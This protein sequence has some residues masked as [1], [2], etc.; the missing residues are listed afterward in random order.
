MVWPG[1]LVKIRA[2]IGN[3]CSRPKQDGRRDLQ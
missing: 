1:C 2:M 3:T